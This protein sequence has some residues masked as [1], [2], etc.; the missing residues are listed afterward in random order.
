M[1]FIKDAK[2]SQ[3]FYRQVYRQIHLLGGDTWR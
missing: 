3:E 1:F 2:R